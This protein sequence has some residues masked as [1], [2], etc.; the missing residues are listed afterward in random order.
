M[1]VEK[2]LA[3]LRK[4]LARVEARAAGGDAAAAPAAK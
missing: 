1:K 4:S 3:K 2:V